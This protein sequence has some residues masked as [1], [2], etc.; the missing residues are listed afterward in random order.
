MR[1]VI[2]S[3]YR[4]GNETGTAHVAEDLVNYF[5]KNNNVTYICLGKK[6]RIVK[7]TRLLTVIKIPSIEIN[8][9]AIPLITPDV[10]YKIFVYLNKFKPDVIHSQNSLFVSNLVQTWANLN[11]IPFVV[12]FHHIPT[13]VVEHLFPKLPRNLI[14]NLVQDLYKE[15]SLKTFLK[16]TDC[17][18]CLNES[19]KRSITKVDKDVQIRIINNGIDFKKIKPIS[20]KSKLPDTI[21]FIFVG[22]YNERKNQEYLVNVFSYLPKNYTLNMY[23]DKKSGKVYA[24]KVESLMKNLNLKNIKI[25]DYNKNAIEMYSNMHFFISASLKEAQSLAIIEALASGIPVIGLKNETASDLVNTSNGLILPKD[26]TPKKFALSAFNFIKDVDYK[27]MSNNA[28]SGTKK[29]NIENVASKIKKV[30]ES[31]AYSDSENGRRNIS[32]YYQNIFKPKIL[33]K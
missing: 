25:N 4:L 2:T 19:V 17:V 33:Q 20:S 28:K 18:I 26:T 11:E 6:F 10:V 15:F 1:I 31:T 30:Y 16:N 14:S 29:F 7:K 3:N 13:Q 32:K 24:D 23:G 9:V 8:K 12:T 27:K 21:N 22:S 5:S